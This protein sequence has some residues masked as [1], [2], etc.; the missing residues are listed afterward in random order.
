MG[1]LVL[2]TIFNWAF[3][4]IFHESQIS[5][6]SVVIYGVAISSD[7]CHHKSILDRYS[8]SFSLAGLGAYSML[9]T[10][11]TNQLN[12]NSTLPHTTY[13]SLTRARHS[14]S[15]PKTQPQILLRSSSGSTSSSTFSP[16]LPLSPTCPELPPEI[17]E[18]QLVTFS[19]P[20]FFHFCSSWR[21]RIRQRLRISPLHFKYPKIQTQD[22][23]RSY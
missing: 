1:G 20:Y 12:S 6:A 3:K 19:F 15:H 10:C 14:V 16:Y 22:L 5:Q 8:R 13:F 2:N 7:V 23:F 9:R 18:P 17:Q 11:A 21:Q 4:S